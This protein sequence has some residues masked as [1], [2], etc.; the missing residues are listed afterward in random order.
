MVDGV[1]SIVLRRV[2]CPITPYKYPRLSYIL[3]TPVYY[4]RANA[5]IIARRVLYVGVLCAHLAP[6]AF[7]AICAVL[8]RLKG[9]SSTYT[10]GVAVVTLECGTKSQRKDRCKQRHR[11][12][13]RQ[14]CKSYHQYNSESVNKHQVNDKNQHKNTHNPKQIQSQTQTQA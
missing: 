3:R 14:T 10:R 7:H 2:A 1:K 11:I 8:F 6:L 4:V 9:T 12:L 5:D 13:L